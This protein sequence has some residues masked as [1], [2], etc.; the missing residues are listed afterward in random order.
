MFSN[1]EF[2]RFSLVSASVCVRD[3][4]LYK[5]TE[6]YIEI[7]VEMLSIYWVDKFFFV[8]KLT[9]F[10]YHRSEKFLLVL[11]SFRRRAAQIVSAFVN[12]NHENELRWELSIITPAAIWVMGRICLVYSLV[13]ISFRFLLKVRFIGRQE[14][15]VLYSFEET[16]VSKTSY[17]LVLWSLGKTLSI[18]RCYSGN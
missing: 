12:E 17:K 13:Y 5:Y 14:N 11:H 15:F 7:Y 18:Q 3:L 1:F 10:S 8:K 9:T 6:K 2:I 4:Y 16:L